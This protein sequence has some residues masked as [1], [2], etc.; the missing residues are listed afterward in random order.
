MTIESLIKKVDLLPTVMSI[1]Q[2]YEIIADVM[3]I[4]ANEI[5]QNK[6]AFISI[7]DSLATS[8]MDNVYE[9]TIENYPEF[10]NFS[11]W[12]LSLKENLNDPILLAWLN[13]VSDTM[14]A[15]LW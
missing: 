3:S 5:L 8:H 7:L 13:S 15:K 1:E 6:S 9:V 12:L 11:K 10:V 2:E 14:E 4:S